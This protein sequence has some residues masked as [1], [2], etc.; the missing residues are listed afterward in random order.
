MPI[1]P[2]HIESQVR[3][4]L[5]DTRVV[6]VTGPRQS[7]KTTLV[8]RFT[9][10]GRVYRTLDDRAILDAA[11]NDPVAFIRDLRDGAVIDEIQ[12]APELL[13]AIKQKVDEDRRPGRFLLTGSA[14]LATI[15]TVHESLAGRVETI[16]LYPLSQGELHRRRRMEFLNR[17]FRNEIPSNVEHVSADQ[18]VQ[19]VSQG[20][21]PEALARRSERRRQD[22]YRAYVA[23]IVDR[24]VPDVASLSKASH[25]P[26]LLQFAAQFAGRLLNVTE[27][28]RSVGLDVKT[29][30]HYLQVLEQ[31]FLVR[32]LQPWSINELSRLVKTP[33]LHFIDSGLLT[34]L[35]G[36]TATRLRGDRA[37]L[38]CLLEG[39][40]FSELVKLIPISE[41]RVTLY[42]YRDRDQ[43]EVDFIL[44]NGEGQIVG[45]EVKAAASVVRKDFA[46]LDRLASIAGN[47]FVQGIV[48]YDGDQA[49]SFGDKLRAA[50]LA[51]IWA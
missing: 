5:R 43:Y 34:A 41:E 15:P 2:R 45:L 44:E 39:F 19:R 32:R 11:L 25:I 14:N 10:N 47:R 6:A 7:G 23:S 4:A 46:G 37:L 26:K 31:L 33:K 13:L 22:W 20:G 28:G 12:R 50:P 40:I 3:V 48:L 27:I 8:R 29:A 49:I 9:S 24:D 1:Y 16:P 17:V 30:D 35:R 18:L 21:Y 36:L 38:G 51:S 42:H